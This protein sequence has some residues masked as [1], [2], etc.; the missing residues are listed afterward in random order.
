M[1]SWKLNILRI[2]VILIL[3]IILC[4]LVF[5]LPNIANPFEKSALEFAHM[6]L[7]L[8]IGMYFTGIPFLIAVFNVFKLLKLIEKDAVFSM[9]SI[10]YLS[11]ISKC[12]ISEII[13]YFVGI[14]YLYVNGVMH[15]KILLGVL[16]MFTAF[17]IYVFIEILKELLLKA[18]EIKAENEL[19]I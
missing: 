17:I 19:T 1:Q 9:N 16:I 6:K 15:P 11:I 10:N 18:V 5:W 12:S 4:V 3:I 13:L 2:S 7:P 8:L 14:I